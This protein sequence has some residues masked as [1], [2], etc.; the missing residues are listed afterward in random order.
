M[1]VIFQRFE[2]YGLK[3]HPEKTRMIAFGRPG[4]GGLDGDAP[5]QPGTFD[6]LGFTHYWGRSRKGYWV[7]KRKTAAKRLRR[8]L[9]GIGE[10]CRTHRH[11]PM[12]EQFQTLVCKLAG[13]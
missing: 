10:W 11:W 12:G 8:T 13:H 6:F 4:K 3:L 9:R 5:H 2:K 7:I 1:R